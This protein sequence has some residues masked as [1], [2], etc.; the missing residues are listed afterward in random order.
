[1]IDFNEAFTWLNEFEASE[2]TLP[3]VLIKDQIVEG[4]RDG[5]FLRG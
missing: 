5:Q 2:L 4:I 1:M 3:A